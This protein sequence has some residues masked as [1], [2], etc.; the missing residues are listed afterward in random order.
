MR[1]QR[2]ETAYFDEKRGNI[3]CDVVENITDAVNSNL[4][5]QADPNNGFTEERAFRKIADIPVSV[6]HPWARTCG[7]YSMDK[8][9]RWR[10]MR[11]FL[12]EH[13]EYATVTALKHDTVNQGSIFIK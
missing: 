7:Y 9:D 3:Y 13:P 1:Q 8:V 12:K 6:F 2:T 5:S 11:M 4:E 10:A